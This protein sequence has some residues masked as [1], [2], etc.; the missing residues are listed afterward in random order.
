MTLGIESEAYDGINEHYIVASRKG[1]NDLAIII[2]LFLNNLYMIKIANKLK[3]RK[4]Y[5]V[6]IGD[7]LIEACSEYMGICMKEYVLT[8]EMLAILAG[9]NYVFDIFF[10]SLLVNNYH[11]NVNTYIEVMKTEK[12]K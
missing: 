2:S 7:T 6:E 3:K 10:A 8:L 12:N 11:K 1:K 4:I 9:I 5:V